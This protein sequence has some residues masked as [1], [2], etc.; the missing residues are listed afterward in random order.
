MPNIDDTK[1]ITKNRCVWAACVDCGKE[2]WVQIRHGVPK[3]NRCLSCGLKT[4]KPPVWNYFKLREQNPQWK[5]GRRYDNAG[6]IKIRL[7]PDSPFYP[8]VDHVGY[9]GEHRLVMARKLGRCLKSSEYVHHKDRNKHNNDISNL[10]LTDIY[11]HN[12]V[13]DIT[14]RLQEAETEIKR[15][16]TLL[17]ESHIRPDKEEFTIES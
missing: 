14:N 4:R 15:L 7:Y 1:V 17:L 5:G 11:T 2:R 3:D 9:V 6:Y 10:E 16:K 8:M 13:G 12:P